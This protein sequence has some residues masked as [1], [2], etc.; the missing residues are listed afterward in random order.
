VGAEA[1]AVP[2]VVFK[3]MVFPYF[4]CY[5]LIGDKM[6]LKNIKGAHD[7][8]MSSSYV[9]KNYKDYKNNFKSLFKEENEIRIEIGMGKGNFIVEMA[10]KYPN[11]NFIGIE[12]YPSAQIYALNKLE[13][14]ELDNLK[15]ISMDASE[16]DEVF[17]KEVSCIY[18]NFSDPWPKQRH[19][20]RRLTHYE[21]LEKYDKV[22]TN[23]KIIMKT[24]NRKLFEFSLESF[25]NYGY[26]IDDLSLNLHQDNPKD[27]IMTEYEMKFSL[28]GDI[29]YMVEVIK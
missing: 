29:I 17:G 1:S 11:I 13:D 20:K 4:F 6:R 14:I 19:S 16:M 26:R 3:N 22:L 21:F 25:V 24:D 8:L 12:K 10:K 28:K 7:K 18:L 2:V 15:L 27:N 9:I 5:N 23:Y